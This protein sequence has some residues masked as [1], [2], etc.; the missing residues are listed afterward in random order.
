[1]EKEVTQKKT[2]TKNT[3]SRS[4]KTTKK[5]SDFDVDA[6]VFEVD[7]SKI[8]DWVKGMCIELD[9][10]EF[11]WPSYDEQYWL[12]RWLTDL[13]YYRAHNIQKTLVS[14]RESAILGLYDKT[15]K[16]KGAKK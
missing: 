13:P 6:F 15:Q 4:K 1:M 8:E 2:V 14:A 7:I 12:G 3:I 5:K 10:P 9:D 11:E 16:K